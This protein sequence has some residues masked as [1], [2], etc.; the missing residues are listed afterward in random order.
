MVCIEREKKFRIVDDRVESFIGQSV[1]K[2]KGFLGDIRN[3]AILNNI[4]VIS[5]ESARLLEILT[6]TKKPQRIL[7]FGTAIGF[8]SILMADGL[9]ENGKIDTIEIDDSTALKA[10]DNIKKAGLKEK[11]NI[12]VGDAA[13]VLLNIQQQYDFVFIDAAKGQYCRY[14]ELCSHMVLPGGIIFADNV[15][16][17]G[18]TAGGAKINR[19]Q[20]LLVRRLR[21]YISTATDD[22]RFIA[23]VLSIGD[24]V[25]ISYKK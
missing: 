23:D 11:I 7:E 14:Y 8:T 19:R 10:A 6:R 17:R 2:Y 24:G 3:E 21:E 4:P 15:L 5:I 20:Q 9:T 25:C 1:E 13:D 12:I 18:M 16:Y 22:E